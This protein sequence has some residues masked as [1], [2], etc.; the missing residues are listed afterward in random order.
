MKLVP[1]SHPKRVVI[2]N[3]IH[4]KFAKQMSCHW[5]WNQIRR[6]TRKIKMCVP[7]DL[8]MHGIKMCVP[9]DLH[10]HGIAKQSNLPLGFQQSCVSL[11]RAATVQIHTSRFLEAGLF[12]VILRFT[13]MLVTAPH[14]SPPG[15]RCRCSAN[16]QQ[17]EASHR[18]QHFLSA[19]IS[20][21]QGGILK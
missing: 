21:A 14:C 7:P 6:E 12:T 1:F 2:W 3:R 11:P 17:K 20:S 5:N 10:M 13:V 16:L 4:W 19:D 9:P 8:H 18:G 15:C